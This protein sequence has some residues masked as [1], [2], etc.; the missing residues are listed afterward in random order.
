[1]E[2]TEAERLKQEALAL[3]ETRA[4]FVLTDEERR[5]VRLVAF[6][7]FAEFGCG[8][9]DTITHARYGGR[10]IIFFPNQSFPEH[11]HPNVGSDG[12][13]ETFRVLWGQVHS[14][15]PGVASASAD[16][17]IPAGKAA[18]FTVRNEQI[19]DPGDQRTVALEAR[20]WFVA[21]PD[22]AVA[23]EISSTIRDRYDRLT[24]DALEVTWS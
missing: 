7:E 17:F 20:H 19:L 13:E 14:F 8:V 4:R 24:D 16:T 9:I 22:G 1:V 12:K 18:T 2:S 23:L 10:L 11:W 3:V 6:G 15:G 5:S 21:G